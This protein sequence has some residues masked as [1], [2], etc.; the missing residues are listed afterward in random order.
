MITKINLKMLNFQ[1]PLINKYLPWLILFLWLIAIYFPSLTGPY[2][3]DDNYTIRL[4]SVIQD[5]SNWKNAFTTAQSYSAIP[6]TWTYRPLTTLSNM[7]CWAIG[8]GAT[9]PFHF[10]K[11]ILFF[12]L[13]MMLYK[14]WKQIIPNIDSKIV[15]LSLF[16]FAVNPVHTQVLSYIS[17]TSTLLAAF[18]VSSAVLSYLFYLEKKQ[19]LFFALCAISV[20]LAILSKEEGIVA[21]ALILLVDIN[22]KK[23]FRFNKK[24]LILLLPAAIGL[25][26]LYL[27][28]EPVTAETRGAISNLHYFLTQLRAYVRYIEMFFV[29]YDLNAD[30]LQFGFSNNFFNPKVILALFTN[31]AGVGLSLYY[32]KTRPYILLGLLWFYIGISPASSF[33]VLAE[34]VND[35]R[36]FIG[37]LGF[38]VPLIVGLD[39][40]IKKYSKWAIACVIALVA[41]YSI[42]TFQRSRTWQSN[43]KVWLDTVDKN[44]DSV[45]ALNNLAADYI[46]KGRNLE[47]QT[48]LELCLKKSSMYA[49]CYI[50]L[51]LVLANLG[52]DGTAE[53][54]FSKAITLDDTKLN[55][56]Y[57]W[58]IFLTTRGYIGRPIL[59]LE[60]CDQLINGISMDTRL[61]LIKLYVQRGTPRDAEKLWLNT[62]T[63]LGAQQSLLNLGK[64]YGF[65]QN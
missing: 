54:Y 61:E 7:I 21:I 58:A 38:A 13:C 29:T 26:L 19:F 55:S 51:A 17:A 50:N 35:H 14:I 27:K 45:R 37:Y 22:Q 8:G 53:K 12:I 33:V 56:R 32:F 42:Q 16:I 18:F 10:L 59:I 63:K 36:A 2:I 44:K 23:S 47:A 30:N 31:I 4:N 49:M 20:L 9:W 39:H 3:L 34:P 15:F 41:S 43:E 28:Y 60:E 24:I 25:T 5:L 65:T 52:I 40:F 46:G 64:K 1:N 48:L 11:I 57:R 62:I 6:S